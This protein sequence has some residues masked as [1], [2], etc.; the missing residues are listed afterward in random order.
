[1]FK[2]QDPVAGTT[3][4]SFHS[5]AAKRGDGLHPLLLQA[6]ARTGSVSGPPALCEQSDDNVVVVDFQRS[7][8]S[9]APK[10]DHAK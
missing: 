5:M 7:A 2:S 4:S 1:M 8:D 9:N 3:L 6:I 10:R